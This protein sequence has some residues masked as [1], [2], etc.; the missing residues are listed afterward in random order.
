MSN[1]FIY[2]IASTEDGPVKIGFSKDPERRLKALQTG[3][4]QKLNLYHVEPFESD[5]IK[6]VED[7]LHQENRFR[8]CGGEWF[9][10]SVTQAIAEVKYVAIPGI[11]P[12]KKK[13]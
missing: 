4:A 9:T 7:M 1:S 6:L 11:H 13:G 3:S 12:T 2:I 8:R 5:D 10:M